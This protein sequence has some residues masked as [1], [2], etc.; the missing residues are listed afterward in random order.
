MKRQ[1]EQTT[2]KQKYLK[3]IKL[4][5]LN[6]VL[7]AR[8]HLLHWLLSTVALSLRKHSKQSLPNICQ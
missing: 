7:L 5:Y 1:L 8:D 6:L 4:M 2:I 3:Q